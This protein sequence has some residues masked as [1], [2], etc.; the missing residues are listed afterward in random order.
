[1]AAVRRIGGR[2]A[3]TAIGL[4]L[5]VT[6]CS[7]AGAEHAGPA[8]TTTT[9]APPPAVGEAAA[10]LVLTGA[11]V[12]GLDRPLGPLDAGVAQQ[13]LGAVRDVFTAT[14]A[15]PMLTGR[16][17]ELAPRFTPSALAA[18]TGPD[19]GV[20]YDEAAGRVA[21]LDVTK[22]DV[23]LRALEHEAGAPALVVAAI[24]W[25]VASADGAVTVHRVG[26]L[27]F[28]PRDDRWVVTSYALLVARTVGGA[29]TTT[30]ATTGASPTSA[31]AG[32]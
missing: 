22:G 25:A 12:V 14:V 21:H 16:A 6:G 28:V 23:R 1:L 5:V 26:D 30:T 11:D 9:T 27:T 15:A 24:D 31:K 7:D 10:A 13:V 32:G 18:A 2:V 19:R 8:A 20:V 4:A 17:G 29:T 3:G